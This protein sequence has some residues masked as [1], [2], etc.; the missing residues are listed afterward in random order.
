MNFYTLTFKKKILT[1]F[2]LILS[3]LIILDIGLYFVSKMKTTKTT[4]INDKFLKNNHFI[5]NNGANK[6]IVFVGSSRTFYQISTNTFKKNGIDIYNFG[7]SG[8]QFEDY[9]A[10]IQFINEVKPKQIVISLSLYKFFYKLG[11]PKYPSIYEVKYYYDLDKI[12]FLKSLQRWVINWHLFLQNSERIYYKLKSLYHKFDIQQYP[13]TDKKNHP[14]SKNM[15]LADYSKIVGCDVFDMKYAEDK[16]II[17]KCTNGDGALIGNNVKEDR[18]N[19]KNKKKF[20]VFNKQTIKFFQKLISDVDTKHTKLTIL[21]EPILHNQYEYNLDDIKKQFKN[22][23]IIDTTNFTVPDSFWSD[24]DHLD[25]KGSQK[26]SQY[27]AEIL[28]K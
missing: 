25:Y 8:S 16:R 2:I 22:V 21:L 5:L 26:Y 10:I 28:K 6:D 20:K 18:E 11:I 7:I 23:H 12:K 9:P 27:L 15:S 3:S 14:N 24:N 17:L 4:F 19:R 13:K 1:A